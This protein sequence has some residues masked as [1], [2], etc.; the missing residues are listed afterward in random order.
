MPFC[1]V[2]IEDDNNN[3]DQKSFNFDWSFKLLSYFTRFCIGIKVDVSNRSATRTRPFFYLIGCFILLTHLSINGPRGI[4]MEKFKWMEKTKEYENGWQ[5]FSAHPDGIIQFVNDSTKVI[6]FIAVPLV[7]LIFLATILLSKR[8][9]TLTAA[10]QKIEKEMKLSKTFY[11]KC[12]THCYL[13]LFLL[14]LVS[15]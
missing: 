14:A 13:S 15:N 8:W 3:R 10:L 1:K 11:Q 4:D 12:R 9:L 6:F 7:H 2:N 5:Y